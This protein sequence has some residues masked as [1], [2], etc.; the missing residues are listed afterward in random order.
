V[1]TQTERRD[2]SQRLLDAAAALIQELEHFPS[3]LTRL[4]FP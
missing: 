1:A 2:E 3:R 4:G